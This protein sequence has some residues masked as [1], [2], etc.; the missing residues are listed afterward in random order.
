MATVNVTLRNGGAYEIDPWEKGE[1]IVLE[2]FDADHGDLSAIVKV[3]APECDA[4]IAAIGRALGRPAPT[5][6]PLEDRLLA[7][8]SD[9]QAEADTPNVDDLY[10]A[11]MA[12]HAEGLRAALAMVREQGATPLKD[13]I[14]TEQGP[15]VDLSGVC[16][17]GREEDVYM[18]GYAK[19][20]VDAAAMVREQGATVPR[21][22]VEAALSP[23]FVLIALIAEES[24]EERA[25]AIESLL[26]A[27][28]DARAALAAAGLWPLPPGER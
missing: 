19:G 1:G 2:L 21:A 6:T 9:A 17:E 15:P 25:A 3:E 28:D 18:M 10:T 24:G 23:V 5:S 26:T 20:R 13:R 14:A 27:L 22:G 4:L 8:I 12:S 7:A 11:Q 16:S